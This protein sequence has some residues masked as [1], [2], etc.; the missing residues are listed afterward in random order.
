MAQKHRK[1]CVYDYLK[2]FNFWPKMTQKKMA[3]F[4]QKKWVFLG[5]GEELQNVVYTFI[6]GVPC[7]TSGLNTIWDGSPTFLRF[8]KIF[9]FLTHIPAGYYGYKTG[10]GG[11]KI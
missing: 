9:D 8:F 4:D 5:P 10:P 1:T 7:C 3:F 2:F 6:S 11:L